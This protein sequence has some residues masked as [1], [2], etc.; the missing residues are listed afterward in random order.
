M[1]DYSDP[2]YVPTSSLLNMRLTRKPVY[3][4]EYRISQNYPFLCFPSDINL[5]V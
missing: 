3:Q 4:D 5:V 2:P 1:R